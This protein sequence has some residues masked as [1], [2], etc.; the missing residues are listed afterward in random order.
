ME[1]EFADDIS[2]S[3]KDEGNE[4]VLHTQE[5]KTLMNELMTDDTDLNDDDE[6]SI[7]MDDT[8]SLNASIFGDL[9][10]PQL[11][12]PLYK[13]TTFM[14]MPAWVK[15]VQIGRLIPVAFTLWPHL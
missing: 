12:L 15:S 13:C 3:S 9:D 1:E 4:Y 8:F 5:R 6:D 11:P 10:P 7:F 2:L 14:S